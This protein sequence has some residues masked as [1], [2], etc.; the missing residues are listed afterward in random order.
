MCVRES[1]RGRESVRRVCGSERE[2]MNVR[3]RE[4]VGV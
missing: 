1:V 2:R 4:R 3:G